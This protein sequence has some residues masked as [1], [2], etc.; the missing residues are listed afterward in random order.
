MEKII[1]E[2]LLES[3]ATNNLSIITPIIN[4]KYN[5]K[6]FDFYCKSLGS[7]LYR[8]FKIII[9]DGT[10]DNSSKDIIEEYFEK[11]NLLNKLKYFHN[12]NDLG[13]LKATL[14]GCRECPRND[15]L[16]FLDVDDSLTDEHVLSVINNGYSAYGCEV[17]YTK[18]RKV[19]IENKK[20]DFEYNSHP[21]VWRKEPNPYKHPWVTSSLRTFR[22]YLLDDVPEKNFLGSQH[23]YFKYI[24]D[25]AIMLPILWLIKENYS[26]KLYFC[27]KFCYDYYYDINAK[28]KI[29][30]NL[31]SQKLEIEFLRQ[32]GFLEK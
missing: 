5:L 15:V 19:D 21:F 20:V 7:Q 6:R 29:Q 13:A 17:M 14:D 16:C 31:K 27:G 32:R 23:K 26:K 24:P 30:N 1:P 11:Y 2:V 25:Q 3:N 8:N 18:H 28:Q 10:K 12:D 4:L 9:E 22:K